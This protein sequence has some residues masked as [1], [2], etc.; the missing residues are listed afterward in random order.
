[1]RNGAPG[2]TLAGSAFET[3]EELRIDEHARERLLDAVVERAA[4]APV[5]IELQQ[6]LHVGTGQRNGPTVGARGESNTY[7]SGAAGH[8]RRP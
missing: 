3:E 8:H 2:A 1:M 7:E 5:A 4:L 6:H